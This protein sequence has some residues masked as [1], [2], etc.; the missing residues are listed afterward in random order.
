MQ[1]VIFIS[2][3]AGVSKKGNNYSI[4]RL[5]NGMDSFTVNKDVNVDVSDLHE[6]D[7]CQAEFHI[8]KGFGEGTIKATLVNIQ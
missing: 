6:G 5:S 7:E 2:S 8:A 4:V 3:H 1:K